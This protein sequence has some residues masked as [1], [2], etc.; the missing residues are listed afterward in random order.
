[1]MV[2]KYNE[3]NESKSGYDFSTIN[4]KLLNDFN[5]LG[6]IYAF[7]TDNINQKETGVNIFEM[8]EDYLDTCGS[9]DAMNDLIVLLDLCLDAGVKINMDIGYNDYTIASVTMEYGNLYIL[10]YLIE[11]GADDRIKNTNGENLW[12]IYERVVKQPHFSTVESYSLLK[13]K[14]DKWKNIKKFKI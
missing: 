12:E 5:V 4:L 2:K 1:M 10:E 11:V 7:K 3:L 13:A 9:I 6:L 8:W 14:Y